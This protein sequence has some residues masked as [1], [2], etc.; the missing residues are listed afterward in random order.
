MH[1]SEG[2]VI[3]GGE[4]RAEINVKM[5]TKPQRRSLNAEYEV[6]LRLV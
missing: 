5:A 6:R 2:W 4:G 3:V 1:S